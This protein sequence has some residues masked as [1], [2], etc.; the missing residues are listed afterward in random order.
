MSR[1]VMEKIEFQNL[2][3]AN[4]SQEPKQMLQRGT[5]M[6]PTKYGPL[7]MDLNQNCFGSS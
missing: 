4:L 2:P 7:L 1:D 3:P 5:L 6:P